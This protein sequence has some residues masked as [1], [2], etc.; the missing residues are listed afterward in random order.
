MLPGPVRYKLSVP[1]LIVYDN[2]G[3]TRI[4]W[5]VCRVVF[6]ISL[7]HTFSCITFFI[8][9]KMD[10]G[11]MRQ[12]EAEGQLKKRCFGVL[13]GGCAQDGRRHMCWWSGK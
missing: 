6:Q 7:H 5:E 12:E 4:L 1:D 9:I 10:R 13:E 3:V 11:V 8:Q 2:E